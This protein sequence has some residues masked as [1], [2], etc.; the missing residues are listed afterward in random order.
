[1][2][3]LHLKLFFPKNWYILR[4]LK[5]YAD[6]KLLNTIMHNQTIEIQFPE[7]SQSINWK[8]DYFKNS[9]E[10][11]Q[12]QQ[13]IYAILFMDIGKGTIQLYLR[14]LKTTCIQAKLVSKEEFDET[15]SL[16][17]YENNQQWISKAD[18]DK[19]TVAIGLLISIM[20]VVYSIYNQSEYRDFLFL[21]S[22][23]SV[24]SLL[25]IILE[26]NKLVFAD[27]KGRMWAS[28]GIFI[29]ILLLIP[30]KDYVVQSL[31]FIFTVGFILRF[32]QHINKVN[33]S[34][35]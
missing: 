23:G 5:I 21:L 29:L 7:N 35:K 12:N 26:K 13:S 6:G 22:G 17:I 25:A 32:V 24:F 15:T 3:T 28:V 18:L 19:S 11:P 33:F 27:Y 20:A 1:M 31:L 4:N 2:R 10:L 14:S 16:S 34:L 30:T 8:L 9:I